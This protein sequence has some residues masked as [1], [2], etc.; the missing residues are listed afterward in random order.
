MDV[1]V[2]SSRSCLKVCASKKET[3]VQV[4]SLGQS[5]VFTYIFAEI[6]MRKSARGV[7]PDSQHLRSSQ[8]RPETAG[9]EA[10]CG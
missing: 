10:V 8:T 2:K 7:R 5:F 6:C 1:R 4:A 3:G 9:I